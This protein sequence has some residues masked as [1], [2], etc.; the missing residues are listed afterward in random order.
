MFW[1]VMHIHSINLLLVAFNYRLSCSINLLN[2]YEM[3]VANASLFLYVGAPHSQFFI[4]LHGYSIFKQTLQPT[5]DL[6]LF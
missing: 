4:V 6:L 1:K 3:Y 2:F 5:R